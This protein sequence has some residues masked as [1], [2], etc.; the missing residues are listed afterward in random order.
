MDYFSEGIPSAYFESLLSENLTT[1][2]FNYGTN[3][4]PF[5]TVNIIQMIRQVILLDYC[6]FLV[7]SDV[8]LF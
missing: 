8:V 5:K 1:V 6:A 7:D 4:Y 3:A 2:D